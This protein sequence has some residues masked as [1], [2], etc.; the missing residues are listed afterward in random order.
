MIGP[1]T[2]GGT[3]YSATVAVPVYDEYGATVI[4]YV[5][6]CASVR[7]S[8]NPP[9]VPNIV[10]GASVVPSGFWIE[11]DASRMVALVTAALIR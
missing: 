2:S 1:V 6:V 3:S 7:V 5:P 8:T 4:V 11:I 9:D 10:D